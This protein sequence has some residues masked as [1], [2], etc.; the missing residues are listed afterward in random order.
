V[1]AYPV[2]ETLVY[3]LSHP[4]QEAGLKAFTNFR[5]DPEW[6]KVRNDSEAKAGGSLTVKV[7]SVY[8]KSLDFSPIK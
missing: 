3:F 8:L 2:E 1:D 4:N 6:I 7:E 5:N